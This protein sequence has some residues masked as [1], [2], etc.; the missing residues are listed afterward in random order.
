MAIAMM[1]AVPASAAMSIG[2]ALSSDGALDAGQDYLFKNID[3][4]AGDDAD[5]LKTFFPR[6]IDQDGQGVTFSFSTPTVVE[7]FV[8]HVH[9]NGVGDDAPGREAQIQIGEFSDGSDFEPDSVMETQIANLPGSFTNGDYLV[10]DIDDI[11]LDANK[12]YGVL[13]AQT[14]Y[15]KNSQSYWLSFAKGAP[16]AGYEVDLFDTPG[17][18]TATNTYSSSKPMAVGIVGYE[19]PEPGSLALLGLGGLALIRRRR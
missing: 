19:V 14:S 5:G 16:G 4:P 8:F 18:A 3:P 1:V 17:G 13:L 12:W 11:Q 10:F 2:R 6:N 9:N 15:K 7:K